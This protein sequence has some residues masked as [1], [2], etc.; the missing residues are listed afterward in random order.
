METSSGN[1]LIDEAD[2]IKEATNYYQQLLQIELE[3]CLEVSDFVSSLVD[4]RCSELESQELVKLVSEEAIRK[5]LFAMLANKNLGPDGYTIEFYRAVWPVVRHN[6]VISVQ[7]FFSFGLMPK[8]VNATRSSLI[9][10]T[11]NASKLKYLRPILCCNLLYK[12]ISKIIGNW[13]K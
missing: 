8:S 4:Y 7:S 5:V 10:K 1:I 3:G 9:P 13:L 6:F 2:I 11:E 12:V